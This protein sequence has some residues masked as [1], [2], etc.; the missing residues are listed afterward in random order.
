[1]LLNLRH[2]DKQ[3][4]QQQAT[5]VRKSKSGGMRSGGFAVLNSDNLEVL[6]QGRDTVQP[7]RTIAYAPSGRVVALG[8]WGGRVL[9]Y[10]SRHGYSLRWN[11]NVSK[12]LLKSPSIQPVKKDDGGHAIP[13][14][15]AVAAQL[16]IGALLDEIEKPDDDPVAANG[17]RKD[18]LKY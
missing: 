16:D 13:Q 15:V 10:D 8:T 9:L 11:V 1:V 6:F 12:L 7:V 14:D 18:T 4:Q 2:T 17:K 5:D 3:Q